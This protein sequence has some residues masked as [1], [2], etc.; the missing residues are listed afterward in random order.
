MFRRF[1]S[2]LTLSQKISLQFTAWVIIILIVFSIILNSVYFGLWYQRD[3][4]DFRQWRGRPMLNM[5]LSGEQGS[6][7]LIWRNNSALDVLRPRWPKRLPKPTIIPL[8]SADAQAI[9]AAPNRFGITQLHDE[10]ILYLIEED[11]LWY[12]VIDRQMFLQLLLLRVSFITIILFAIISY[13]VSGRFVR[14]SLGSLKSLAN[15]VA[16]I[17]VLHHHTPLQIT[18]PKHDELSILVSALNKLFAK[19]HADAQSLKDFIAHASHELKTP[20]MT[21]SALIDTAN[22]TG[23][24]DTIYHDLKQLIKG[25]DR[26]IQQLLMISSYDQMDQLPTT[27]IHI[28]P[29]II[30][31]IQDVS[32][33]Y[34]S[35]HIKIIT[36]L[37]ESLQH[38]VHADSIAIMVRNI[39]D[40]A[41]HYTP[42]GGTITINLTKTTLSIADTGQGIPT[43]QLTT[44]WQKFWR[45]DTASSNWE[46]HGLGLALCQQ[47]ASLQGHHRTVQS[48]PWVGS[49][50]TYHFS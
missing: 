39:L 2:R 15:N 3:S 38:D 32:T 43:H 30:Q 10:W 37:P 25:Q 5:T 28:Q 21:M 16:T 34:G 29:I 23:K 45:A 36:Q 50:F 11:T 17:D 46:H 7:K 35:K 26:L 33:L 20:L 42:A 49:V 6:R 18:G 41:F 48:Q 47:L 19:T 31:V 40:N 9:I 22:K 27:K 44:I 13:L 12:V 8:N 1:L 14:L 4:I 24:S